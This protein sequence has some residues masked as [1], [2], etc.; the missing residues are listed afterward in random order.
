M[1]YQQMMLEYK[2][3][4]EPVYIEDGSNIGSIVGER[5]IKLAYRSVHFLKSPLAIA[6]D[7]EAYRSSIKPRCKE[8]VVL[9]LENED[10]YVVGIATFDD[11]CFYINRGHGVQAAL[12]L[13]LWKKNPVN[14]GVQETLL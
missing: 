2:D 4:G 11:G 1:D 5:F 12:R 8:I 9:E 10:M 7:R 6:V 3:K 14:H 13:G